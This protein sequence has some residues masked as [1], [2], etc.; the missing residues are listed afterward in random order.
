[1]TKHTVGIVAGGGVLPHLLAEAIQTA[2]HRCV[3]A[4]LK[5][6]SSGLSA[7]QVDASTTVAVGALGKTLKFMAKEN[8]EE[9]LLAGG[10]D[11]TRLFRTARPDLAGL[12]CSRPCLTRVMIEC[13]EP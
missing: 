6:E 10:V 11:K 9:I 12:N 5:G 7:P 1:M 3:V 4:N 8:V 2:G 13:F